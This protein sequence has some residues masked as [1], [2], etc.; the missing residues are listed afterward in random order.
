MADMQ[1][2]IE[3]DNPRAQ[4]VSETLSRIGEQLNIRAGQWNNPAAE[5]E[6]ST[7]LAD[8]HATMVLAQEVANLR[9]TLERLLSPPG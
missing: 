4:H 2:P 5:M 7:R 3:V 1:R 6:A 8:A 9:A